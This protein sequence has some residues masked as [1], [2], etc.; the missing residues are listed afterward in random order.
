LIVNPLSASMSRQ[1]DS[2]NSSPY[3]F[4]QLVNV[5]PYVYGNKI[6]VGTGICV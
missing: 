2:L 5:K 6:D 3:Y 4:E 1:Y